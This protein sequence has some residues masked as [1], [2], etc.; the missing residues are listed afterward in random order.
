MSSACRKH[1]AVY[2][3]QTGSMEIHGETH[4]KGETLLL[5]RGG[6]VGH[7]N[8]HTWLHEV[9]QLCHWIV[10]AK[11]KSVP[12]PPVQA[13]TFLWPFWAASAITTATE[14]STFLFLFL[15]L[16]FLL[17]EEVEH[18]GSERSWSR[19]KMGCA[20]LLLQLLIVRS[21]SHET[22]PQ[23]SRERVE[24]CFGQTGFE[25]NTGCAVLHF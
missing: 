4:V 11:S 8:I 18:D 3:L 16:N 25:T 19:G 1:L 15:F 10:P 17:V 21:L 6:Y 22:S 2:E 9:T 7:V 13:V 23:G 14:I 20:L 12:S 24:T 5:T